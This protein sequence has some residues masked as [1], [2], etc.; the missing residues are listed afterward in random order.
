MEEEQTQNIL[1]EKAML[2]RRIE[3]LC[4]DKDVLREQIEE[5][6]QEN[7]R[8]VEK[9]RGQTIQISRGE[10]RLE[11]AQTELRVAQDFVIQIAR[12]LDNQ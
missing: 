5:L 4:S 11:Q 2:A 10:T 9:S 8:L 12:R 7:K 1:D 3:I 6:R